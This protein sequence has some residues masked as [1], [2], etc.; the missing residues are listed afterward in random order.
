MQYPKGYD[1]RNVHFWVCF[2]FDTA[3][4]ISANGLACFYFRIP[5]LTPDCCVASSP[6]LT[7]LPKP[8]V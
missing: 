1:C 6:C 8:N 7:F 5:E 3:S 2:N 4:I